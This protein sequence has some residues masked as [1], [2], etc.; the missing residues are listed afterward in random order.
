MESQMKCSLWHICFDPSIPDE[1]QNNFSSSK[2]KYDDKNICSIKTYF[3]G[4]Y[5]Y[6]KACT[7][8]SFLCFQRFTLDCLRVSRLQ[9]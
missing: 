6:R 7:V 9:K 1:S 3:F 4:F 2:I 8:Q 5:G